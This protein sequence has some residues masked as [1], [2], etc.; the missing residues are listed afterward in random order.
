MI[1]RNTPKKPKQLSKRNM[2]LLLL[3][4]ITCVFLLFIGLSSGIVK[5][6]SY[7]SVLFHVLIFL[8]GGI[9]VSSIVERK[10]EE[11]KYGFYINLKVCL[12]QLKENKS[13]LEPNKETVSIIFKIFMIPDSDIDDSLP[14]PSS[15]LKI[16]FK[17]I[18]ENMLEFFMDSKNVVPPKESSEENWY[19]NLF[20]IIEFAQLGK[21]YPNCQKYKTISEMKDYYSSIHDSVNYLIASIDNE[22][23]GK[24]QHD[25]VS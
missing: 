18:C 15:E 9:M 12:M 22:L 8:L 23:L 14:N 25:S 7:Y 2:L 24:K 6:F 10:R 13:I 21:L 1:R 3:L 11:A 20:K 4:T 17:A 5:L 19:N 16:Y